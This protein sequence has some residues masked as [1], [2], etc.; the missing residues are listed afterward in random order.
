VVNDDGYLEL[1]L[2]P[3]T[4]TSA[5]YVMDYRSNIF[6]LSKGYTSNNLLQRMTIMQKDHTVGA[7]TQLDTDTFTTAGSKTLS[8]G[9][10]SIYKR[11]VVEYNASSADA[12]VTVT[13]V[14]NTS[15]TMTVAGTTLDVDVTAYGDSLNSTPPPCGEWLVNNNHVISKAKQF[16]A[17]LQLRNGFTNKITNVFVPDDATAATIASV[18][19]D[20]FGNR[21]FELSVAGV[22]NPLLEINDKVM[23]FEHYTNSSSI[24]IMTGINHS[25]QSNGAEY[26]SSF[27]FVDFGFTLAQ[28]IW[29]LNGMLPGAGDLDFDIGY[30]W[31]QDLGY[32]FEDAN[33]Y[34]LT[35]EVQFS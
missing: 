15:I 35:K 9:S 23:V 34:S 25:F 22:G 28:L 12:T 24:F 17:G 32:V 6:S 5:D 19:G 16:T 26:K 2:K 18:Y 13:A 10:E 1:I 4:A 30:L 8:W 14:T 33:D 29:D 11:L 21:R 31:E 3:D 7:E 27:K 20:E